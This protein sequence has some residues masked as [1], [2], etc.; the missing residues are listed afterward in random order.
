[1]RSNA[2]G[3]RVAGPLGTPARRFIGY[4]SRSGEYTLS[5]YLV[6]LAQRNPRVMGCC[7]SPW[8]FSALPSST[9]IR[10]PQ[11]SGQSCGQAAWTTFRPGVLGASLIGVLDDYK[12]M[13]IRKNI[14]PGYS[15]QV[16]FHLWHGRWNMQMSLG[17]GGTV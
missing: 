16:I 1:M 7:G 11:A 5:I 6:T 4:S 15:I 2:A 3:P 12:A 8:I 14:L 17:I 9:V 13:R 10:T